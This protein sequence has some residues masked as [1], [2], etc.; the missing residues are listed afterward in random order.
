MA[1]LSVPSFFVAIIL[2][3]FFAAKWRWLPAGGTAYRRGSARAELP[4]RPTPDHAGGSGSLVTL[5]ITA[6]VTRASIVETYQAISSRRCA[7]RA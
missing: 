1:G 5:A 7:P 4:S 2:L 6:R 3:T